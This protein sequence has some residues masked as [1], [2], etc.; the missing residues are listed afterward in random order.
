MTSTQVPSVDLAPGMPSRVVTISATDVTEGGQTQAGQKVVFALSDTLDVTSGGDVI[1]KTQATVT[2]D[3][4]GEG[5]IRLPVYDEDVRTW[6]GREWAIL[7]SG[8][9]SQKAIRVPAGTSSIALSALPPVRPLRGRELQWA[10]TGTSVSVTE[11]AVWDVDVS[12]SGGILDFDFTVPPGGTAFWKGSIFPTGDLDSA[13]EPGGYFV[14]ANAANLPAEVPGGGKL[15]VSEAKTTSGTVS[16]IQQELQTFG[17]SPMTFTRLRGS[18]GWSAWKWTGGSDSM[19]SLTIMPGE[20]L[21]DV[22]EPGAYPFWGSV[23]HSPGGS[24]TVFVTKLLTT[25]GAESSVFQL[26]SVGSVSEPELWSRFKGSAGWSAWI[27]ID[28]GAVDFSDVLALRS[29]S[30]AAKKTAPLCLSTGA[31]GQFHEGGSGTTVIIQHMPTTAER[32]QLHLRNHNPRF[33]LQ[34]YASVNVSSV[35]IGLHDGSGGSASW[36][37]LGA[38]ATPYGSR[39]VEVPEAWRGKEIAVRY[40]WSGTGTIHRNIGTAWTNGSRDGRPPL[41]AWLELSVPASTPV[42]GGYGDSLTAGVGAARP[43]IDSWLGLWA[44][45]HGAVPAHWAHSGD[46]STT[47]QDSDRK[48]FM[49]GTDVAAPDVMIYAMGSNEVYG[50]ASPDLATMKQRVTDTVALI[51]KKI[52]PEV[53]GA[54]VMPRTSYPD[55]TLRRGVN[56]WYPQSGLFR[57]VFNFGAAISNDDDN[58]IPAYDADG[59]HLT[60]AG[61][62][63]VAAVIPASIVV[64]A[65]VSWDAAIAALNAAAS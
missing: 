49:Y 48:W 60:T 26:A 64:P 47:W 50:G 59:I 37:T 29:A 6:C 40:S 43:V 35:S 14:W 62:E 31:G 36:M 21:D 17:S 8:L 19:R 1:A 3:A 9:G 41:W 46:A 44:R 28:V 7:V 16:Q 32:A 25:T 13:T 33:T 12:L 51:K 30:P 22:T 24:G 15:E 27:R 34:D 23:G 55:E 58:I 20:D 56:A 45:E 57:Q 53:V 42:V 52:T 61:Y 11:G 10:V 65:P 54:L 38:G 5:S 2:L 18:T 39:W 4:N 63:A